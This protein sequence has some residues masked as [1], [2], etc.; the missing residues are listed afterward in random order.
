MV[1]AL[2][3]H[4]PDHLRTVVQGVA[5]RMTEHE[6]ASLSDMRGNMSLPKVPD[7]EAYERANYMSML[8]RGPTL[9]RLS[10]RASAP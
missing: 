8:Q 10:S 6:W 4:G 2:L 5:S 3:L 7:P 9:A 1:S